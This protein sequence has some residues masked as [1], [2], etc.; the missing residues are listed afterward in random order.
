MRSAHSRVAFAALDNLIDR[1]YLMSMRQ[2]MEMETVHILLEKDLA[3][4]YIR[5]LGV[6][7]TLKSAE[8]EMSFLMD[9]NEERK[10]YKIEEKVII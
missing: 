4:E 2:A 5:V 8:E 3:T 9:F 6:Y 7:A 10:S 1:H